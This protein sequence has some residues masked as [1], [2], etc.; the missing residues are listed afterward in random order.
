V[1]AL[2]REL[3]TTGQV[4]HQSLAVRLSALFSFYLSDDYARLRS[5]MA[6]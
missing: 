3:D 4:A 1:A 6:G 5:L 2:V